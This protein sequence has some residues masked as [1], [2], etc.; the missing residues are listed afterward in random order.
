M[1]GVGRRALQGF[2]GNSA[3]ATGHAAA[4]SRAVEVT[5]I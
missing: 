5:V 3:A 4:T 1:N 2:E